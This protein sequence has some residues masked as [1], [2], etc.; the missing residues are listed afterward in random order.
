MWISL[1]GMD[2]VRVRKGL[3]KKK[4]GGFRSKKVKAVT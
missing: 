2:I 3:M 1:L 4:W